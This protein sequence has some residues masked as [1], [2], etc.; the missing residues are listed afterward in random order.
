MGKYQVQI[1]VDRK[2]YHLGTYKSVS[3]A[4]EKFKAALAAK[5]EG[6]FQEFW[7]QHKE[8]VKSPRWVVVER[9]GKYRAQVVVGGKRHYL[10]TYSND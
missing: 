5:E 2:Q 1:R 7:N 4:E 8:H 3:E 9:N 10:G 6:R